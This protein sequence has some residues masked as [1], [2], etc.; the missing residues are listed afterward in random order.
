MTERRLG[1]SEKLRVG[2]RKRYP[3]SGIDAARCCKFCAELFRKR[4][5]DAGTEA[6]AVLVFYISDAVVLYGE[7]PARL[8]GAKRNQDAPSS[9]RKGVLESVHNKFGRDKAETDGLF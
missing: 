1:V 2:V 8:I 9:T 3:R 7:F 5:N 4:R 6:L